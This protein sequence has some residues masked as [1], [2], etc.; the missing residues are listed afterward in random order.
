MV[1][2]DHRLTAE[3]FLLGTEEKDALS[4]TPRRLG[5]YELLHYLGRGNVG[6]V[7]KARD[8]AQHRDVAVKIFHSDLQRSE[9]HFL[10]RL[11]ND[12]QALVG[13]RHANIVPVHDIK[14]SRPAQSQETTAYLV[15]EYIEG[16]TL[17]NYVRA[18]SHKGL[19]PP[20]TDIVYL[21]TSL[22]VAID[23]AH[24]Q[25]IMHGNIKP[26]NILLN[27]QET[28]QFRVGEPMLTDFGLTQLA[29]LAGD[30]TTPYYISPEQAQGY[31][32]N[33]R[34]DVYALGVILY[35]LCTG[36]LPF[37]DE[38][39]VAVMMQHI[40]TLPTP[41]ILINPNIPQ[42][43][44]EVILRALGKDPI[45][46]F[47]MASLLAAAIADACSMQSSLYIG[48]Q[49]VPFDE[50][51]EEK[52]LTNTGSF[53]GVTQPSR[54][55]P[56]SVPVPRPPAKPTGPSS[57]PGFKSLP[58][59]PK[60]PLENTQIFNSQTSGPLRAFTGKN[61]V[62][63]PPSM[64]AEPTRPI[65]ATTG[66]QQMAMAADPA[67]RV[68]RSTISTPTIKQP[69]MAMTPLATVPQTPLQPQRRDPFPGQ[70]PESS[71]P[72]PPVAA[73]ARQVYTRAP[74]YVITAS[75]LLIILILGTAIGV[76]L[77]LN[78]G[79]ET[80]PKPG[81]N[82]I[83]V[84][85][86]VYFQDDTQGLGRNSSLRIDLYNA[87]APP[88][89]KTYYAWL[90]D[91]SGQTLALGAFPPA[92]NGKISL[93]Y[94]GDDKHTNLLSTMQGVLVTI[95]DADG[96]PGQPGTRQAYLGTFD[97]QQ[98]QHIKDILYSTPDLPANDSVV[99]QLLDTIRSMND[100]AASISD[101]L[102]HDN[103][104][105]IRQ[106]TRIIEMLDGS[107]QAKNSGDLPAQISSQGLVERGLLSSG[108]KVGY[109]ELL[110]QQL[111]AFKQTVGN[112]QTRLQHIQ[113]VKNAVTNLQ[114]WLQNLH[115]NDVQ[116]LKAADLRDPAITGVALQ[117]KQAA[118]DSYTGRT[119]PPAT[120]PQPEVGSAGAV[121]AYNEAQ[122]LAALDLQTVSTTSQ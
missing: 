69:A 2:R 87:S 115:D 44:S 90:Q 57:L 40:R 93:S 111:D 25:G 46:R 66:P 21:F 119:I 52:P 58:S 10:T 35:E 13:L 31:P 83:E 86:R 24:Q 54:P 37:R 61:P 113:G 43:L 97:P 82:T 108:G 17:A 56:R 70:L 23:H 51:E 94:P 34:S 22:G 49:I 36:T 48:E 91:T 65:A 41:P 63:L 29:G 15:M 96:K 4:T 18:T 45:T 103:G 107:E 109:L 30:N 114:E 39:S 16:Q 42:A 62:V 14:V 106:A 75:L 81:A 26:G 78:K 101:S 110:S 20:L 60:A 1:E 112:D 74:G 72:L 100:K 92:E 104:L 102:N 47:S 105:V 55:T 11:T 122:Y 33:N 12:G 53:L 68:T 6:E 85:G 5:Q 64:P 32:P 84:P 79:Q 9:Q 38:S 8:L 88:S 73:R 76:S 98:L 67:E 99:T 27:K 117:I 3:L 77:W 71:L 28:T 7:W 50:E 118:A 59:L 120:A 95:E 116:L 80:N 19:F 89:G 121:Q